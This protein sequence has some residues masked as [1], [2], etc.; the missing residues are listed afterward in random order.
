MVTI[1]NDDDKHDKELRKDKSGVWKYF[2]RVRIDGV[3]KGVYKYCQANLRGDS[4]AGT[5]H[6]NSHTK[7][8]IITRDKII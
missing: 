3:V 6:L 2:D 5:S 1:S 4:G 8:S 7:R